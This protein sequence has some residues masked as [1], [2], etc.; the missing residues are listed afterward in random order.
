M[1]RQALK[2]CDFGARGWIV[3]HSVS[4]VLCICSHGD[5]TTRQGAGVGKEA[6]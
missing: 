2:A 3:G 6:D 1:P 4:L 5:G